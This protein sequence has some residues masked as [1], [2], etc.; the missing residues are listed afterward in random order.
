MLPTQ[1]SSHSHTCQDIIQHLV[2]YQDTYRA[3]EATRLDVVIK[4]RSQD[5]HERTCGTSQEEVAIYFVRGFNKFIYQNEQ[6]Q[7]IHYFIHE[8]HEPF[9]SWMSIGVNFVHQ[10]FFSHGK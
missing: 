1:I 3:T 5:E 6:R 8:R 9:K 4:I 2:G 7:Y 10:P